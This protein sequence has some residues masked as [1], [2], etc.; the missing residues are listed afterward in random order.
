MDNSHQADQH[1]SNNGAGHPNAPRT[2]FGRIG[3]RLDMIVTPASTYFAYIG[4]AVLGFLVLML[5]YSIIARRVFVSPLSGSFEMTE[6]SLAVITFAALAYHL[7][8]HEVMT[9]DIIERYIPKTARGVLE[10]II[11]FL[12]VCMLGILC[13]QLIVQGIR[14]QGFHQTTRFL[15]IPIYPFLYLGAVGIFVLG[16]VY[17]RYFLFSLDRVVKR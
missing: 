2:I 17:L 3:R 11:K 8:R 13:W 1:V 9:V 4:A 12:T 5:I 16:L 6:L 7:L 14:V 15:R 10:V